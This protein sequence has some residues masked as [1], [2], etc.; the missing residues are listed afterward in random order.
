MYLR[1]T[2]VMNSWVYRAHTGVHRAREFLLEVSQGP[3]IPSW[4]YLWSSWDLYFWHSSKI[5]YIDS[6]LLLC[7]TVNTD[8]TPVLYIYIPFR[9][10]I[11]HSLFPFSCCN[12]ILFADMTLPVN[13][14][15]SYDLSLQFFTIEEHISKT[16]VDL[17][18]VAA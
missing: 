1:S 12:T 8:S 16:P 14:K 17:I 11:Y 3:M 18:H 10:D 4:F 9:F 13:N 7:Y 2:D 15:N 6:L 5:N